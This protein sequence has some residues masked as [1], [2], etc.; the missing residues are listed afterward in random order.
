MTPTPFFTVQDHIQLYEWR[1][2]SGSGGDNEM[3][4]VAVALRFGDAVKHSSAT[5]V[6]MYC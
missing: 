3:N 4:G 5:G 2:G 6:T 1:S